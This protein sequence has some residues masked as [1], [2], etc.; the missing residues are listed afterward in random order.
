MSTQSYKPI[1]HDIWN[2]L[3]EYGLLLGIQRF[4]GEDNRSFMSRLR[5]AVTVERGTSLQGLLNAISAILGLSSYTLTGQRHFQLSYKP[6]D[7]DDQLQAQSI[8]VQIDGV[9]QTQID[10]SIWDSATDGFIVWKEWDGTY[11]QM[12]EFKN[13]PADGATITV[14]YTTKI[15]DNYVSVKDTFTGVGAQA[16]GSNQIEIYE[17]A[18]TDFIN[19][20]KT[21]TGQLDDE[22][23]RL[24]LDINSL[25]K[26]TWG[27]FQWD[28]FYWDD[29]TKLNILESYY[30]GQ[31]VIQSD[32]YENGVGP[33][34]AL[35]MIGIN[36][37][38]EAL[39]LPGYFYLNGQ[40][41]Y[42]FANKHYNILD[43]NDYGGFIPDNV[44]LTYTFVDL[45]DQVHTVN[46]HPRHEAPIVVSRP[47]ITD[48]LKIDYSGDRIVDIDDP[49]LKKIYDPGLL[50]IA[51]DNIAKC[52]QYPFMVPM[53]PQETST[54]DVGGPNEHKHTWTFNNNIVDAANQNG[55][56]D[57]A[58]DGHYHQITRGVVQ[59]AGS[60]NHTHTITVPTNYGF[61]EPTPTLLRKRISDPAETPLPRDSEYFKLTISDDKTAITVEP[62]RNLIHRVEFEVGNN[63]CVVSGLTG[64]VLDNNR[65]NV[66]AVFLGIGSLVPL[67][68]LQ[69]YSSRYSVK[70][71][72]PFGLSIQALDIE[73]ARMA[74]GEV[75]VDAPAGVKISEEI[76]NAQ[77]DSLSL[78]H[79]YNDGT[80]YRRLKITYVDSGS[81]PSYPDIDFTVRVR[82]TTTA[83]WDTEYGLTPISTNENEKTFE[84]TKTVRIR[85]DE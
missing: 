76:G 22:Y 37:K 39:I 34:D 62:Y 26:R 64:P 82:F 67:G 54:Y 10:E 25:Y 5:S 43:P 17:V 55:Y 32:A 7:K 46:I 84:W 40:E 24:L 52:Y 81:I 47:D 85:Y 18:S 38:G 1:T 69:V 33:G 23:R 49:D 12:L 31:G 51:G 27:E 15:D 35:K 73:G 4:P 58:A 68:T 71:N 80:L 9:S 50:D 20:H 65:F 83:D 75:L 74:G 8:N 3:D 41:Y 53:Q 19:Q 44:T 70:L 78:G 48:L 13:A 60:D 6:V 45:Y 14:E 30:D 59:P 63:I 72:Q 2:V 79:I 56:T 21:P 29:G 11:G 57:R 61:Y 36:E 66:S 28:K 42:L 77:E 16:P